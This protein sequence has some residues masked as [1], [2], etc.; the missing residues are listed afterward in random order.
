MGRTAY[1][2]KPK[3]IEKNILWYKGVCPKCKHD[4]GGGR[5]F[6][7]KVHFICKK[8]ENQFSKE[9][10][11]C[12]PFKTCDNRISQILDDLI[13]RW[14][15]KKTIKGTEGLYGKGGM[16]KKVYLEIKKE[17]GEEELLPSNQ[18]IGNRIKSIWKNKDVKVRGKNYFPI[19]FRE[20]FLGKEKVYK[21]RVPW[22]RQHY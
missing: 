22:S 9:E 4:C 14:I 2:P 18:T 6:E 15:T 1:Y 17:V 10:Y 7:E 3:K 5:F 13:L 20:K 16:I 8:C 21:L 12:I 19:T 11:D